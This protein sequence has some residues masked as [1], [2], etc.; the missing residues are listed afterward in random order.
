MQETVIPTDIIDTY[1]IH[2]MY[3]KLSDKSVADFLLKEIKLS[4]LRA[5]KELFVKQ[6][7]KYA[8]DRRIYGLSRTDISNIESNLTI[9]PLNKFPSLFMLTVR[10]DGIRGNERWVTV[11]E[12]VVRL[13]QAEGKGIIQA[14]DALNDT[15]HNSR[16]SILSKFE[17]CAELYGALNA[18]K[19]LPPEQIIKMASRDVRKLAEQVG[20]FG[21]F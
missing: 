2:L 5:F 17:N 19:T 3:D 8:D 18:K 13:E 11:A 1:A 15:V 14:I 20:G 12:N 9:T 10:G 7:K 16:D 4:Y 6:F 21:D